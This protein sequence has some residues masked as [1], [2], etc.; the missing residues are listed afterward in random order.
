[1]C[2]VSFVAC[3]A[4]A[5]LLL[6]LDAKALEAKQAQHTARSIWILT[7]L[8]YALGDLKVMMRNALPMR[9]VLTRRVE[10]LT[11]AACQSKAP[12]TCKCTHFQASSQQTHINSG[13]RYATLT[14]SKLSVKSRAQMSTFRIENLIGSSP[15]KTA[16][17]I[18]T[19]SDT[20][21]GQT[22]GSTF[23]DTTNSSPKSSDD[24]GYIES[25]GRGATLDAFASASQISKSL[26]RPEKQ[27]GANEQNARSFEESWFHRLKTLLKPYPGNVELSL[28]LSRN[29]LDFQ[30]I[31][32]SSRSYSDAEEQNPEEVNGH[33]NFWP[34]LD[35]R[36][37]NSMGS[38]LMGRKKRTRAAF[39]HA[40]V[41]ELEKRF[42]HQRYLSG[43]ERTELARSLKLSETQVKIWFQNRRYKTKKRHSLSQYS[44]IMQSQNKA[45]KYE[46]EVDVHKASMDEVKDF[47]LDVRN[48]L[49]ISKNAF[50]S[51]SSMEAADESDIKAT[52]SLR[53]FYSNISSKLNLPLPPDQLPARI[54]Q[55]NR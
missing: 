38:G 24:E 25:N 44:N 15:E 10:C 3:S 1:M 13:F 7:S 26:I 53:Q 32:S 46:D 4:G 54:S 55:T 21:P 5:A 42:N 50:Y 40:Q 52:I 31:L 18:S 12:L 14:Q 11:C 8:M 28:Q 47:N 29:P 35:P 17:D 36:P 37:F 33:H 49:E 9:S 30:A 39:S 20:F 27:I 45:S 48:L 2:F 41:F 51:E 22:S 34:R 16:E 23:V 6:A 19:S 43:P